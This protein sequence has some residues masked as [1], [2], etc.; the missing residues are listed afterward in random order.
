M[1]SSD[2]NLIRHV[3]SESFSDEHLDVIDELGEPIYDE[4]IAERLGLKATIVRTLLNDLHHASLVEYQR[5]KNKKTGWYTYKWLR[6]EEKILEH[7]RSQLQLQ[8]QNLES[9][10]SL[11][12]ENLSFECECR[13]VSYTD[14]M[15]NNFKCSVCDKDFS[16][17]EDKDVVKDLVSEITRIDCILEKTYHRG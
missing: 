7:V 4:E 1:A 17:Y 16:E 10:L 15:D 2:E 8:R 9:R 3:L 11:E 12:N 14:A 5:S 13:R 6:R